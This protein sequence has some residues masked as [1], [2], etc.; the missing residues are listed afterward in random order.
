MWGAA[1]KRA[2]DKGVVFELTREWVQERVERGE[3]EVSGIKFDL[4]FYEAGLSRI[5]GAFLSH[6]YGPSLDR[7]NPARG[8]TEENCRVICYVLN[9][10]FGHWGE[11]VFSEI[12]NAYFQKKQKGFIR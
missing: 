3:C 8:Y 7:K 4:S 12:A 10:A 6:P 1:K 5:D 2:R 9:A 11:E